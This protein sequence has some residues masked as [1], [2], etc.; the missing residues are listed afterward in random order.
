[1]SQA[2]VVG[3]LVDDP[4]L[5]FATSG[6]AWT[7]F[8]VVESWKKKDSDERESHFYDCK[9][10]GQAAEHLAESALKGDTVVV[11]GSLTQDKWED[12]DGNK[13]SKIVVIARDVGLSVRWHPVTANRPE[14]QS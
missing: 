9:M 10:F 8:T 5:M 13:R 14:R 2:V 7:R 11:V 6:N 12:K 1:M 4:E 3:N